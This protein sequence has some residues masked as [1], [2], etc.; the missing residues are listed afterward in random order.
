[1][2]IGTYRF[3]QSTDFTDLKC[4][5]RLRFVKRDGKNILQQMWEIRTLTTGTIEWR[6]VPFELDVEDGWK[7][8]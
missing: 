2:P 8:D 3:P 4:T 5:P 6:D 7:S 1:M